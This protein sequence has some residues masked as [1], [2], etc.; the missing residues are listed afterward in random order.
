SDGSDVW[1]EVDGSAEWE[2]EENDNLVGDMNNLVMDELKRDYMC[3]YCNINC[4]PFRTL[5]M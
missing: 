2:D 4:Q 3:L 1:E 5:S